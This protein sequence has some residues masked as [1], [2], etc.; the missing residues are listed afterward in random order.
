MT[1]AR[2]QIRVFVELDYKEEF[3]QKEFIFGK[4]PIPLTRKTF[5]HEEIQ[6]LVDASLYF[7]L[8]AGRYAKDFES[9]FAC[10]VSF[11]PLVAPVAK[12]TASY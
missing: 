11:R 2:D 1:S 3:P 4:S 5:D 9:K 12:T 7:W 8:T 10:K 6:Y